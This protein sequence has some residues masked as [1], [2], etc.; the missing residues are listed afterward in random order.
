MP[1]LAPVVGPLAGLGRALQDR[2]A[3]GL[4]DRGLLG[5]SLGRLAVPAPGPGRPGCGAIRLCAFRVS[6]G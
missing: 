5:G 4:P 1:D 2:L 3:C 6:V